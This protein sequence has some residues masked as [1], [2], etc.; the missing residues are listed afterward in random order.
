MKLT[1]AKYKLWDL[2]L[3][4]AALAG[5]FAKYGVIFTFGTGAAASICLLP[6]CFA[7]P[8]QRLRA[9]AWVCSL[10]P[11]FIIGSLYA[12]WLAAWCVLGH[13]P[14]VSLD[15]PKYISPIVDVPFASTM[16]LIG[17]MPFVFFVGFP[18][19]LDHNL[20]CFR[21]EGVHRSVMTA[22]LLT[23]LL[24]WLSVPAILL[25]KLFGVAEIV[26]WFLD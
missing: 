19:F 11:L 9:A 3:V 12:T 18:L 2:M 5:L 4:I 6:I 22:R 25:L 8:G 24:L 10:Y 13:Q 26:E 14:R 20:R 23:P 1:K 7:R 21:S 15:D 17:G 16:V